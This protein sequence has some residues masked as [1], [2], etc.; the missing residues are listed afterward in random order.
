MALT[1]LLSGDDRRKLVAAM[2]GISTDAFESVVQNIFE[3][4]G[5]RPKSVGGPQLFPLPAQQ[6]QPKGRS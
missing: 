3:E 4:A 5:L 1:G 2:N 6:Q